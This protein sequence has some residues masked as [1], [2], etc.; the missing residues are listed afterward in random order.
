MTIR[1]SNSGKAEPPFVVIKGRQERAVYRQQH[2]PEY[3]GNPLIEAL[4][5]IWNREEVEELLTYFPHFSRA[6]RGWPAHERLHLLDNAREFFLPRAIHL[7]LEVRIS[8]MLRRGLVGR[9]PLAWG[10]W[11]NFNRQIESIQPNCLRQNFLQCKARGF[12]IVGIG[13]VGKTS[14]I[15]NILS[16]YPQVICHD[17]YN[18]QS[19]IL[20]QLVWLYLI[21]PHDGSTKQFCSNFFATIDDILGTSYSSRY[22]SRHTTADEMLIHM[23]RVASLHCL[24]LLIID[25]IQNLSEAKSGGS[26]KILN[27]FVQLEDTIHVPFILIG[28]PKAKP[29][30]TAEFRHARR[31]SEQGD[32]DW[33]HM[34]E[35]A[36]RPGDDGEPQAEETWREYVT[37]LFSYQY[38][39]K[40]Y[41]L[42]D[43]LLKDPVA[44]ALY[45]ASQ[46]ITAVAGTV[47]LL[48]QRRAI[49]TGLEQLSVSLIRSVAADNQTL[50]APMVEQIRLYGNS[51]SSEVIEEG[52]IEALKHL[53]KRGKIT[54][55][56]DLPNFQ[57]SI[58]TSVNSSTKA[59]LSPDSNSSSENPQESA[60]DQ[61]NA[62]APVKPDKDKKGKATK[63]HKCKKAKA[64]KQPQQQS[65]PPGDLRSLSA[66]ELAKLAPDQLAKEMGSIKPATEF[67]KD[68]KK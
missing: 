4:P 12:A 11:K 57:D 33:R 62:N 5:G 29:V 63:P 36:A 25:D 56:S 27:F 47:Y 39:Q 28:T 40:P 64:T 24:G 1:G 16:L 34:R 50:I 32:V 30:L 55:A 53:A 2:I 23:A 51:V 46:G 54:V 37:S 35:V 65:Y 61:E 21:V 18:E 42:K 59:E 67:L 7:D 9:N 52:S 14:A 60:E 58:Y 49:T 45:D 8:C 15:L 3:Q 38:V 26:A 22:T 20:K 43:D 44:H 13:G 31:A 41:Q 6:M 68:K 66:E 48:A 10:Y 17:T 19:L